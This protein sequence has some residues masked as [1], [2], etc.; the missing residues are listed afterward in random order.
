MRAKALLYRLGAETEKG[1]ALRTLLREAAILTLTAEA[2]QLGETAGRLAATNAAP[3]AAP[4]PE[5]AT[6]RC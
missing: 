5:T 6:R 3:T 2:E 4:P 1:A